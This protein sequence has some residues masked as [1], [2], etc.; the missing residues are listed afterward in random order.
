MFCDFY[1]GCIFLVLIHCV[2]YVCKG[3][4]RCLCVVDILQSPVVRTALAG[5]G[6]GHA[7]HGKKKR[8]SKGGLLPGQ[9]AP[10]VKVAKPAA[11]A[12]SGPAAKKSRPQQGGA[13]KPSKKM[14]LFEADE[15][16]DEDDED[17]VGEDGADDDV[18]D[19]EEAF[20]DAPL[21]KGSAAGAASGSSKSS[22][23]ASKDKDFTFALETYTCRYIEAQFKISDGYHADH[24]LHTRPYSDVG[25]KSGGESDCRPLFFLRGQLTRVCIKVFR[26]FLSCVISSKSGELPGMFPSLD[27]DDARGLSMFEW[28]IAPMSPERFF[29]EFWEKKPLLIKRHAVAPSYHKGVFHRTDLEAI[30]KGSGAHSASS[31]SSSAAAAAAAA[32]TAGLQWTTDIDATSYTN[33]KRATHNPQGRATVKQINEFYEK[34]KYSL[35]VLRPQQHH[36]GLWRLCAALEEYFECVVGVNTYL[37]PPSSQGASPALAL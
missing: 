31:S 1:I 33:G 16:D 34:H 11:K 8:K 22:K 13:P 27:G 20:V 35:R 37:T 14:S 15:E 4:G 5:G 19:E 29:A 9:A 25:L 17:D 2:I 36:D 6:G 18:D 30:V 32:T 7:R 10:P 26:R 3:V 28:M 12:G 24:C 21:V 23:K